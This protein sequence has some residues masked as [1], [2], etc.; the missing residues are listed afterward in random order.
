MLLSALWCAAPVRAQDPSPYGS[1]HG[2]SAGGNGQSLPEVIE[3]I[4]KAR[5]T[6]RILCITAHP[7]DEPGAVLAYL[8][9]GLHADVALLSLTR[10]EGGQ[11]ALGPEQA[12]QLG[13][14]R[15]EELMRA[16]QVYGTRLFF[17]R[18]P[19]FGYTKTPEEAM[20]VW[21]D[22]VLEDMVRVIR[23]FR[24]HVIINNWGGVRTGHGH[25][26]ASGILT[27]KA[28]AMAADADA[29][30]EQIKEGL[31]PWKAEALLQL[32]RGDASGG[33]SIPVSEISALWGKSWG[34]IGIEGYLNHRTQGVGGV[35]SSPFFRRAITL[36]AV[37]GAKAD[38]KLLAAPL[39]ALA[40]RFAGIEDVLL[41]RLKEVD[42]SLD[43]AEKAAREVEWGKVALH[44]S[45][46]GRD[47][48]ALRT[49]IQKQKSEIAE[50]AAQ[51]LERIQERID[52]AMTLALGLRMEATAN[53][54]EIVEGEPFAVSAQWRRRLEP[55]LHLEE[56]T[57]EAP[58]GWVQETLTEK[59]VGSVN[60]RAAPTKKDGTRE[61]LERE[62]EKERERSRMAHSICPW[63][64]PLA[65]VSIHGQIHAY[66]ISQEVPVVTTRVTS[67][68][69]ETRPLLMVPAVTLTVEPRRF[70]VVSGGNL[71]S[72]IG[73]LKSE[74]QERSFV[75]IKP[76]GTQDDKKR[77]G[78]VPSA[79]VPSAALGTGRASEPPHF[80]TGD[81]PVAPTRQDTKQ[82]TKRITD[83]SRG[84]R[85][86][87]PPHSKGA[88]LKPAPTEQTE[89]FTGAGDQH[90]KG[91][92]EIVVRVRHYATKAEKITVGIEAP[93]GWV[94]VS[95]GNLKSEIGDLKSEK[96]ERSFVPIKPIGTQDDKK[97]QGGVPSAS[98]PSAALGTGKAGEPPHFK[99]GDLPV[100]P[101]RQDTEQTT[102]RITEQ[103]VE[104][105]GAGDQLVRFAVKP[106][107]EMTALRPG[108]GQAGKYELKAYARR[109]SGEA[110]NQAMQ[111]E[112]FRTS[113]EPLP[114]LPT[115][116]WREP[117][118]AK[119]H[120]MDVAVPKDLRVGYVA[121]ENDP[122]PQA[123]REIGVHVEL[124]DEAQ[125]AFGDLSKYDAIAI[126][127]RAYELR[128]DLARA[129]QRL[130]DYAAAGG[131]LV[132]QYQREGVW[133]AMK[134]APYPA[135]IGNGLRTTDE[136][137][138]VRVPDPAHPVLNFPNA[139][140]AEDFSGWVQERGLYYWDKF[141]AKYTPVLALKDPGE[142][143]ALGALV[144][145]RHGKGVYIYTGLSF[146][147][148]LPE[149]VA[150]AYR[151][152]VN[153]LS[154]GR[155]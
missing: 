93:A 133:N 90:S 10:G 132:V 35:R 142:E 143:E 5:V 39:T 49:D 117:A 17:T 6:T 70:V 27:P 21:G 121:A 128:S 136:N 103:T 116:L 7:D 8:A 4:E 152:F 89:E 114:T 61:D 112:E 108:S 131:T 134:P 146:F 29:F 34:E 104:F 79:S 119:V 58:E 26:Q 148:Q 62:R 73:D 124:L 36:V 74:K 99:T 68:G 30:P 38:A 69:S 101:T 60:L 15:T 138:P 47:S 127:I 86:G 81:L 72:E 22:L 43:K 55:A 32:S 3:A 98:V 12:P 41:P 66:F 145:A 88:G 144:T 37:E 67:V 106:P 150:G 137:S 96:Q 87:E 57:L 147:R 18:A 24:P 52:T 82:T 71:K 84:I 11:N 19:D 139:I 129:N 151:L 44:L 54:G 53:R 40:G 105:V 14:I 155:Q 50:R 9:R 122:I 42:D 76:I 23:T 91:E 28:Y 46:A 123:L 154:Q 31:Q 64:E 1:G 78:G 153:L 126:G 125:L 92:R 33:F 56:P 45:R 16:T 100:A 140:R 63:P 149:G 85:A 135:T 97:R 25:H 141:D 20:K 113:L 83:R 80:K 94:V 51:E 118:V 48:L 115:R 102:K 13:V 111:G 109:E 130:L 107:V 65:S 95:G 110:Q 75:P 2:G 59:A 120:V 77:Q